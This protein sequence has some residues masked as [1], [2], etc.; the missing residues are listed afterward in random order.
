MNP[1][2]FVVGAVFLATFVE[3]TVEYLFAKNVKVQP[4]LQYLALGF[5][6]VVA[7]AY[8][9]DILGQFGLVSAYPFV[10]YVVSGLIIGRGSN[11]VNDL[12]TSFSLQKVQ[13]VPSTPGA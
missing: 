6:I 13:E 10:G 11:Y 12:V 9:V 1:I 7:I 3:G 8:K 2:S 5:G 4:Y